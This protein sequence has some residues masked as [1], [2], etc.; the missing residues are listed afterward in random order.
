MRGLE[1]VNMVDKHLLVIE[2]EHEIRELMQILLQRTGFR[3]TALA[4]VEEFRALIAKD[5]HFK[6]DLMILD[7]MLPG[8][9][10]F[11]FLK[12]VRTWSDWKELPII[13]V[14]AK[15]EPN[16]VV[17]GLEA[18]ADDYLVKPFDGAVLVA[19]V[20][21]L[22]RRVPTHELPTVFE[23]HGLKIDTESFEAFYEGEKLAL[24]P[25]EFKLLALM[26]Q[27]EGKV[28]TREQLVKAVQGDGINVIGR[29][30][31]THVF[32]LRKKL[33]AMGDSIETSRGIG[34]R[35]RHLEGQ[36]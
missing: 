3:V 12:E 36:A 34:Y 31:D 20:K 13:M 9:S 16:E 22:L 1:G 7:W 33:G 4:S 30:V 23:W 11:D 32:S 17:V 18:G 15:A 35:F 24:T 10:G 14:T 25:T 26:A 29:T 19:R 8:Q 5:P 6:A 2:D 21:A 28:F 27:H